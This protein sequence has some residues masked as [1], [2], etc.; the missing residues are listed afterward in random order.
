MQEKLLN[1]YS[2]KIDATDEDTIYEHLLNYNDNWSNYKYFDKIKTELYILNTNDNIKLCL[3][4]NDENNKQKLLKLENEILKKL[5]KDIDHKK[6]LLYSK[7]I[8]FNNE[9]FND[10]LE[11]IYK[12]YTELYNLLVRRR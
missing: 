11:E 10:K 1:I 9:T 6:K 3:S 7:N 8:E 5:N 2:G 4:T 12:D